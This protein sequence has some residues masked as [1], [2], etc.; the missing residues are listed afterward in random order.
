MRLTSPAGYNLGGSPDI[1]IEDAMLEHHGIAGSGRMPSLLELGDDPI[2]AEPLTRT[3]KGFKLGEC[4]GLSL[5][6][7]AASERLLQ[8]A[9]ACRME[10]Y[11][12]RP[13]AEAL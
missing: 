12:S 4:D 11:G 13:Q 1:A 9:D 5:D 2:D 7:G 3:V 8:I 6:L 10:R